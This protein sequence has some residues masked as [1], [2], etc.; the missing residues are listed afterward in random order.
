M[1]FNTEDVRKV[2]QAVLDLQPEKFECR[3]DFRRCHFCGETQSI[4]YERGMEI[5]AGPFPHAL[6]CPVLIAQDLLT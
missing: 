4:D 1:N 2:A 3:H 6:D 5:D